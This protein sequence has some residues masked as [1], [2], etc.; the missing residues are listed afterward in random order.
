MLGFGLILRRKL[1]L[2]MTA[3]PAAAVI[4][5]IVKFD[6]L[7]KWRALRKARHIDSRV[8]FRPPHLPGSC[9]R[10]EQFDRQFNVGSVAVKFD[11]NGLADLLFVE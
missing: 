2:A 7:L 8:L 1:A 10:S 3:N 5:E 11:L 9:C 6:H 4:V